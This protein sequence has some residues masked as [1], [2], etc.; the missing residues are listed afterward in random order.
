MAAR[1]AAA[2]ALAALALAAGAP[3]ARAA[4]PAAEALRDGDV[5]AS[6]R[7][8][9]PAAPAAEAELQAAADRLGAG[10]QPV[11]LAVVAGPA[12][13]PSMRVY[14]RRLAE[15]VAG[16]D[17]TVVVTAPRRPAV[18]VGPR[19]PAETTR[20][21]RAARVGA[22]DDPVDR[23][24][25]AAELAV[26]EPADEGSGTR[27]VLI[28]LGLAALGAA[29]AVAWGARR[30]A[31]VE[32]ERMLEARAAAAVRLDAASARAAALQE[33]P[34]LPPAARAEVERAAAARDAA[35]DDLQR[36]RSVA[37]VDAVAPRVREALDDLARAAAAVGQDQPA[38]DPF[39][40]LCAAD[41]AHGPAVAEAALEGAGEPARVCAA[42]AERAEA[43]DPPRPRLVPVGGRPVPF[44]DIGEDA[45]RPGGGG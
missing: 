9:G 43:G 40:G 34:D 17:D 37:D 6:P 44:T 26:I 1:A 11:K 12:G 38:D 3:A 4:D 21:F 30:E 24:V 2:A 33:R 7:A 8:L 27:A 45:G 5:Y 41:P 39:A 18:A 10:E 35:A 16:E 19:P 23:V 42:C 14:A 20:R 32:R 31:R 28:L 15:A 36:A 13:A 25:R 29:W 22:V